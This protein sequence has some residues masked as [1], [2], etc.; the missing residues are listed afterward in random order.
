MP[1]RTLTVHAAPA[2]KPFAQA[3]LALALLA[4]CALLMAAP[5]L[6]GDRFTDNGDGTL[7][8]HELGLV[9]SQTDN[10]GDVDWADARRWARFTFPT[11]LPGAQEGWRLPTVAELQSLFRDSSYYGGYESSCGL[12][13]KVAREFD[14]SCAF[15]WATDPQAVTAWFYNFQLGRAY[16]DR[17]AKTRGYRALAVRKAN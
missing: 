10:Q 15:V 16:K 13:V 11:G 5:A 7:T 8:D 9:W 1:Q 2:T 17:K 6:A 3:A 4:A 14:L 12:N